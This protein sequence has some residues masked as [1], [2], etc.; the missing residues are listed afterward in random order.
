MLSEILFFNVVELNIKND[1]IVKY[2]AHACR[3]RLY[4][5]THAVVRYILLL[6]GSG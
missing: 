4:N 5:T 2:Q 6:V 3:S 1:H